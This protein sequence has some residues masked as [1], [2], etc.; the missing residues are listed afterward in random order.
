MSTDQDRRSLPLPD[1]DHLPVA[2]LRD[3][4]R[5]LDAPELESLLG[6]E[7][8]HG[9]R[10]PVLEVLE[11]RLAAVQAGAPLSAGSPNAARPESAPAPAGRT[12]VSPATSGPPMNPASQGDP[13]NPAQPR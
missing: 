1:Y 6:Y 5:S 13:T 10:L 11:H 12:T 7:R 2:G 3:R 4:I 8:A 9:H